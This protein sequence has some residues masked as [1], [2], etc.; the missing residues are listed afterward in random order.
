[1]ILLPGGDTL[2]ALASCLLLYYRVMPSLRTM[3]C[4]RCARSGGVR[5]ERRARAGGWGEGGVGAGCVRRFGC[6]NSHFLHAAWARAGPKQ[7]RQMKVRAG[8]GAGTRGV[9]APPSSPWRLL[10]PSF[11]AGGLGRTLR[12]SFMSVS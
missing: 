6:W 4:G 3:R 1:M 10:A 12:L 5:T 11:G 9:E 2:G 7:S 8:I